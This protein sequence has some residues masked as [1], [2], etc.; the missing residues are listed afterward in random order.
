[1]RDYNPRKLKTENMQL[2][3]FFPIL[4][5]SICYLCIAE[6]YLEK[7]GNAFYL[8]HTITWNFQLILKK[9]PKIEGFFSA[10]RVKLSHAIL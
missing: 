7:E 9:W 10:Y 5:H 4:S 6:F 8:F 2:S 1:M 3:D